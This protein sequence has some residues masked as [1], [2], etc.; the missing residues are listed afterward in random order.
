MI[1]IMGGN[2][3]VGSAFVRLCRRSGIPY[4]IIDRQNYQ[5]FVGR[6]CDIFINANGNSKKFLSDKEPL[7]DFDASIRTVCASLHDFRYGKY[8]LCSSCDVYPDVADPARNREDA[9]IESKRLSRYGFHK[10][11][12]EQFVRYEADNHLIFRCG[13]FV[14]PGMKK[15]AI[16]DILSGGPL[17]LDPESELQFI[18]TDRAADIVWQL[19]GQGVTNETLNL[20]GKGLIK[21]ASVIDKVG[22]PVTVND[23]SPRVTYHISTEKIEKYVEI[24]PTRE[25][26]TAFVEARQDESRAGDDSSVG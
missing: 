11:V 18:H 26:V 19:I 9:A 8:I 12:A 2:G 16:F 5:S 20:C 17:W 7:T 6:T 10:Y 3:F 15:N 22:H 4:A 13:G 25:T 14:G 24:P 1:F 23:G 21:L